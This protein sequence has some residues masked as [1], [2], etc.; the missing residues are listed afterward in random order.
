MR[1]PLLSVE[2]N[3][4]VDRCNGNVL[5]KKRGWFPRQ[6]TLDELRRRSC[7]EAVDRGF[8]E[9]QQRYWRGIRETSVRLTGRRDDSIFS[10]MTAALL[11]GNTDTL[12]Q[13][14]RGLR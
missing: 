8:L 13:W 14:M 11:N 5:L 1:R 9:Y 6:G 12:P 10:G 2:V 3:I 4:D 7:S